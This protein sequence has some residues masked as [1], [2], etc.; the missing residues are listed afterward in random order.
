MAATANKYG[1]L[2]N[3]AEMKIISKIA[4]KAANGGIYGG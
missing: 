3:M 1:Y 4:S 2:E